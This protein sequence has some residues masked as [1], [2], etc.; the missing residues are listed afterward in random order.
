MNAIEWCH[1]VDPE[2]REWLTAHNGEALAQNVIAG[3]TAAGG[4]Y[5]NR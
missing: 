2:F 3:I 5:L 1:Q 4:G